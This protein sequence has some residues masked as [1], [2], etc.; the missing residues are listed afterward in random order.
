[1]ILERIFATG[2]YNWLST[3]YTL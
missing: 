3:S 1:M 2:T